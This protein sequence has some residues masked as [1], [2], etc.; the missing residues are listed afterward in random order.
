MSF[1]FRFRK[2]LITLTGVHQRDT[3]NQGCICQ[4]FEISN[5]QESD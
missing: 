5:P 2:D 3:D 4:D 1:P